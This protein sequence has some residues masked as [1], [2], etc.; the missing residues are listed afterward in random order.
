MSP[1]AQRTPVQ[2]LFLMRLAWIACV[3]AIA[4]YVACFVFLSRAEGPL[5]APRSLILFL[6]A[7]ALYMAW[8]SFRRRRSVAALN[9][10]LCSAP[11]SV[12]HAG[13]D[14][15][16]LRCLTVWAMSESVAI[17]GLFIG[18][19]THSALHF[20][21]LAASSLVLLYIHRPWS[22]PFAQAL[23]IISHGERARQ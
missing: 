6:W 8:A 21:L 22:A 5:G 17:F 11:E 9:T 4:S 7:L 10:A 23:Q 18:L 1:S 2:R 16:R 15:L 20:A 12:A 19:L 14:R 13:I 3:A